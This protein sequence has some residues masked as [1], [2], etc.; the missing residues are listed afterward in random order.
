LPSDRDLG[1]WRQ[2]DWNGNREGGNCLRIEVRAFEAVRSGAFVAM[3][4]LGNEKEQ[5]E[6]A[7]FLMAQLP[8]KEKRFYLQKAGF[9]HFFADMIQIPDRPFNRKS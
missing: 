7:L 2:F 5:W 9:V 4:I 6:A 1:F 8:G 3:G